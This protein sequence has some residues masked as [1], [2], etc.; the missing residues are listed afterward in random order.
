MG[1]SCLGMV[2]FF[3][4]AW[5]SLCN[6]KEI[7]CQDYSAKFFSFKGGL[8]SES[9]SV[10]LKSPEKGAKNY[11]EHY[12]SKEKMLRIWHFKRNLGRSEKLS[13][14]NAPLKGSIN[15]GLILFL[16]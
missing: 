5:C 12:P 4:S 3:S 6:K 9:F 1:F 11:L 8:I 10:W 2:F 15:F 7:K 13:E 16:Y 14:I